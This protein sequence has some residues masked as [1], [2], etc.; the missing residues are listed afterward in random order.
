MEPC[1]IGVD[2]DNV[3]MLYVLPLS[4]SLCC[5]SSWFVQILRECSQMCCYYI[6]EPSAVGVDVDS[7]VSSCMF[8]FVVC[9][10][11]FFVL[12]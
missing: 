9:L 2:V 6:L 11:F 5:L 7:V 1:A 12:C 10:L 3:F 4:R 8:V